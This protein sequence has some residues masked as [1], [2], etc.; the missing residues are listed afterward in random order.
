MKSLN[1]VF[2]FAAAGLFLFACSLSASAQ[3]TVKSKN[4][5]VPEIE[6]DKLVHDYGT[7]NEGDD[8]ICL[9]TFTNTGKEPLV[10]SNVTASCGCTV[11]DWS[12]EPVM[13]GKKGEISVKY[14]TSR[15]GGFSKN[16][17]VYSNAASNPS[18]VLQIKGAVEAKPVQTAPE[19]QQSP[20]Q[21]Q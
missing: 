12:K 15:T 21:N 5:K 7:I 20:V 18:V 11:P 14:N 19:K 9:F 6:F 8:G 13:P 10:L 16:V 3:D 4:A 2:S 17:T 1:K